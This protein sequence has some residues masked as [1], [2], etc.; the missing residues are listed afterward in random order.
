MKMA[1]CLAVLCGAWA[2]AH[3]EPTPGEQTRS[4]MIQAANFLRSGR[5]DCARTMY[6]AVLF[7][8][9][10]NPDARQLIEQ[11]PRSSL[12]KF[13][14]T[15]NLETAGSPF[16]NIEVPDRAIEMQMI[17]FRAMATGEMLPSIGPAVRHGGR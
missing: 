2:C 16:L 14:T 8:D 1:L 11:L 13:V 10:G 5:S 17:R 9:P 3:G 7:L 15:S 12:P 4:L 6:E